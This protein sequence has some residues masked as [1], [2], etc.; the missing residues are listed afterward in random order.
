MS[1]ND[2]LSEALRNELNKQL[3]THNWDLQGWQ[4]N[5]FLIEAVAVREDMHSTKH[6]GKA[7]TPSGKEALGLRITL[8]LCKARTPE[9]FRHQSRRGE[10]NKKM[11]PCE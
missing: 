4:K 2:D 7:E 8:S 1:F 5:V 3:V 11:E 10:R 9:H 6:R